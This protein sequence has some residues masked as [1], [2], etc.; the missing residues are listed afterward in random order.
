M[1]LTGNCEITLE[2][3]IDRVSLV[4]TCETEGEAMMLYYRMRDEFAAG[5]PISFKCRLDG[6]ETIR[7]APRP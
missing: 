1:K 7:L 5:R 4:I 6:E 3:F 2:Q